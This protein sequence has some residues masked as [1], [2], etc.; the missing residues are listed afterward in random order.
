MV[1]TRLRELFKVKLLCLC[2]Q[3]LLTLISAPLPDATVGPNAAQTLSLVPGAMDGPDH[4]EQL[5]TRVGVRASLFYVVVCGQV[6]GI[7]TDVSAVVEAVCNIPASHVWHFNTYD[8]A[9][10][11]W[12]HALIIRAIQPIV[13][14]ATTAD[15]H[16]IPQSYG[17]KRRYLKPSRIASTSL[18][19]QGPARSLSFADLGTESYNYATVTGNSGDGER[20]IVIAGR[21]PGIYYSWYALAPLI[22]I[23][24]PLNFS[25]M[26]AHP[27]IHGLTSPQE[28]YERID[29]VTAATLVF[30]ACARKG[31][32][33]VLLLDSWPIYPNEHQLAA[34]TRCLNAKD[35]SYLER[36]GI[37]S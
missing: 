6:P 4:P 30:E 33:E 5:C 24:V 31:F 34:C 32:V 20:W 36:N 14:E 19:I 25:R 22:S 9:K 28:A 27:Q 13:V 1:L 29:N 21:K 2:F 23:S 17:G 10:A 26:A 37:Y 18:L 16:P 11:F 3:I 12:R 7:Y 8:E 15:L 35:Q